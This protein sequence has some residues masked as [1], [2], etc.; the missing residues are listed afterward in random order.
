MSNVSLTNLWQRWDLEIDRFLRAKENLPFGTKRHWRRTLLFIFMQELSK[1]LL[2]V[3]FQDIV[4][5]IIEAMQLCLGFRRV[6]FYRINRAGDAIV[7]EKT[8]P[9]HWPDPG[10]LNLKIVDNDET[11]R[12]LAEKKPFLVFDAS[13]LKMEYRDLLKIEGPYA[14]IPLTYESELFGLFCADMVTLRI[15]QKFEYGNEYLEQFE[16]FAY[17]VMSAI[18]NRRIFD[19][20]NQKIEQLKLIDKLS[21]IILQ[22]DDQD[23]LLN[24]LMEQ[25]VK[26]V[27]ATGGH[28]KVYNQETN[29]LERVADYGEDIAPPEIQHKPMD[30]GYSNEVFQSGKSLIIDDTSSDKR[31]LAHKKYCRQNIQK[32]GYAKYL[33]I[34]E[35][36][37][38]A[39]LVP[40]KTSTGKTLG[41][42]DLH[43]NKKNHFTEVHKQN[44]TALV[45]SVIIA[46]DKSHQMDRLKK[47]NQT[48]VRYI[49]ILQNAIEK[50]YSL[51]SVLEIIRNGCANLTIG[52]VNNICLFLID[53]LSHELKTP[54]VKC[55]KR[56]IDCE[57]CMKNNIFIRKAI[58][59]KNWQF[60]DTNKNLALPILAKRDAVGIL[61][62]EGDEEFHLSED[63]REILTILSKTAAIL[64]T[65]ASDYEQKIK[66]V[67][68]LYQA[69]QL[70]GKKREFSEWFHPVMERV[71]DVLDR[72]NRNFHLV[73]VEDNGGKKE[74]VVKE[75]SDLFINGKPTP[76]KKNLV[77]LRLPLNGSVSGQAIK[78]RKIQIVEDVDK[79]RE[80]Q[81]DNPDEYPYFEYDPRIKAEVVMP[82]IVKDQHENSQVIGTLVIDSVRKGDFHEL[83]I[84]FVQTIADYLAI[85]IQNMQLYAERA[86]IEEELTRNDR[87]ATLTTMINYFS[88]EFIK[89][90]QEIQSCANLI[91]MDIDDGKE[92]PP[93]LLD[94]IDENIRFQFSILDKFKEYFNPAQ[95]LEIRSVR[96][97]VE[98]SLNVLEKTRGLELDIDGNFKKSTTKIK[99]YPDTLELAFRLIIGN[100][101]KYSKKIARAQRYLKIDISEGQGGSSDDITVSFENRTT[102]LIPE[103]KKEAIFDP[104]VRGTKEEK[105]IG[106]G[107][108][109]ARLCV[110]RH[111]GEIRA[112]NV[113]ADKVKFTITMP[114]KYTT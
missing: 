109:L 54:T 8:S 83:D 45:G 10:K 89:P 81:R 16:T 26:L 79:H 14:V 48:R 106:L 33:K 98:K 69:G 23:R 62:L 94:H 25:S 57:M 86:K 82:M 7:L 93:Y 13:T 27:K 107:L 73:L 52:N 38:S 59:E 65:T 3:D 96:S 100:A 95:D 60:S 85:S 113:D 30:I 44:V 80:L 71:M 55:M 18:E 61:Y 1:N 11:F 40:L 112:E 78:T 17:Y 64:I 92:I 46:L 63:E 84:E 12:A 108:A 50:S 15:E 29:H 47:I 20:R 21:E 19:H 34:L 103:N 105:G 97:L 66:Q 114:L 37:K 111:F 2:R 36:R 102:I 72:D 5:R 6:R 99:C 53:P 31:M 104:Y 51:S 68:T 49:K 76:P 41:V 56:N 39:L 58:S 24:S 22:E 28:L 74:L 67:Q 90:I 42:I 91:K 110:Q 35:N 87:S 9:A 43:S 101:A 4:D 88:H 32:K 75:T 77:G 70:S